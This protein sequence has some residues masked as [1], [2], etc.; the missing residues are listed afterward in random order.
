M[1][2]ESGGYQRLFL[3]I[4]CYT[5][6]YSAVLSYTSI[7]SALLRHTHLHSLHWLA[8]RAL[9]ADMRSGESLVAHTWLSQR[10]FL[11]SLSWLNIGGINGQFA[12]IVCLSKLCLL[13]W[14]ICSFSLPIERSP[15]VVAPN[16][17]PKH[18][19]C[20]PQIVPCT[21]QA[22]NTV[23]A[24]NLSYWWDWWTS[25]WSKQANA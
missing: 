3:A 10:K 5:P 9:P 1:L 13:S 24:H 17:I 15:P 8:T 16:R 11:I 4:L 25:D 19:A 23:G 2:N 12:A 22:T 20:D 14:S 7:Y 21:K 18:P 6:L